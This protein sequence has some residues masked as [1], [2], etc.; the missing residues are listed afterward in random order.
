MGGRISN[1]NKTYLAKTERK[2]HFGRPKCRWECTI[3]N[4]SWERVEG[5]YMNQESVWQRTLINTRPVFS[6]SI[7]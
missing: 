1:V 2:K 3:N 6:G 4:I 5:I 7:R